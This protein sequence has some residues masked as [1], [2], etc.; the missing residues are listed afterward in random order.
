MTLTIILLVLDLTLSL[1]SMKLKV[2]HYSGGD[3]I[4]CL[5]LN[6]LLYNRSLLMHSCMPFDY[7]VKLMCLA[8]IVNYY[9]FVL[10]F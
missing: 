10:T 6:S 3:L 1:I 5:D 2:I 9:A 4:V 7:Q 8:S